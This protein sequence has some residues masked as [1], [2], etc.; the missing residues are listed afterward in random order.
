MLDLTRVL[1]TMALVDWQ[2]LGIW[3]TGIAMAVFAYLTWRVSHR[4]QKWQFYPELKGNAAY[5]CPTVGYDCYER[6]NLRYHGIR[7]EV[8]ITNPGVVQVVVWDTS[9]SIESDETG[10]SVDV[11][12]GMNDCEV[13]DES[14]K[15]ANPVFSLDA[16]G[17]RVC[18][19]VIFDELF[20]EKIEGIAGGERRF[21]LR[22]RFS[23]E[24]ERGRAR[25]AGVDSDEFPLPKGGPFGVQARLV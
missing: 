12:P 20:E 25:V 14:D 9:F 3:F 18:K 4:Q 1:E 15:R 8:E 17:R 16:G 5:R 11:W 22:F 6:D 23:W 10:G 2:A 24:G 7:W 21:R 13:F 19:V